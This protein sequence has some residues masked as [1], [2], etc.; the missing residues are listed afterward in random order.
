MIFNI[1]FH[2]VYP[3]KCLFFNQLIEGN[4]LH[5]YRTK[6]TMRNFLQSSGIGMLFDRVIENSLAVVIRYR[7]LHAFY[8]KI[9]QLHVLL[10][11]LENPLDWFKGYNSRGR[12]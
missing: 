4:D 11:F 2:Q 9:I 12:I 3:I 8:G 6:E 10:K 1:Y 5:L 7:H